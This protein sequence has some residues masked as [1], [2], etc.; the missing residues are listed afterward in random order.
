VINS[1]GKV[2]GLWVIGFTITPQ[3]VGARLALHHQQMALWAMD[4]DIAEEF[5]KL[6]LDGHCRQSPWGSYRHQPKFSPTNGCGSR[7]H[8]TI[9]AADGVDPVQSRYDLQ[10]I[11]QCE[12]SS[13]DATS[14]TVDRADIRHY[15]NGKFEV[16]IHAPYKVQSLF[17]ARH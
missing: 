14:T 4:N 1:K 9:A 2:F 3:T 6:T 11:I 10:E 17:S 8:M 15:G 12:E 7:A 13:V 16:Y 5:S